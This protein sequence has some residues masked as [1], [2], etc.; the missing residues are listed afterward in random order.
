M[1]KSDLNNFDL[2]ELRCGTVYLIV[3]NNMYDNYGQTPIDGSLDYYDDNLTDKVSSN[4]DIV[5]LWK[6]KPESNCIVFT[7]KDRTPDWDRDSIAKREY[8]YATECQCNTCKDDFE[9]GC[10]TDEELKQWN[11][12]DKIHRKL[13]KKFNKILDLHNKLTELYDSEPCDKEEMIKINNKLN[14]Q[15]DK[16]LNLRYKLNKSTI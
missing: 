10:I 7:T 11:K 12:E 8:E 13:C 3:D 5:K 1:K 15:L 16:S 2:I 14:K 6:H 9:A 4:A